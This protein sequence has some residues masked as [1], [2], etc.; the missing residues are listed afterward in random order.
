MSPSLASRCRRATHRHLRSQIDSVWIP[1]A[2]LATIFER[3]CVTSR[4]ATRHGSSVPGPMESRRRVGKR[5]M[6][7]LSLGQSQSASPLWVL[8]NLPD[9]TQW[10]WKPPS[11]A[12]ARHRAENTPG[13]GLMQAIGNWLSGPAPEPPDTVDGGLAPGI[14]L[15]WT[16][17]GISNFTLPQIVW[18]VQSSPS[19]VI[20]TGLNFFFRDIASGTA[21]TTAPSLA[22]FCNSWRD[23]LTAGIF[24]AEAV[25]SVLDGIQRGLD[26]AQSDTEQRLERASANKFKLDILDATIDGLSSRTT[27]ENDYSDCIAWSSVLQRI[28]ELQMNSIRIFTK[29]MEHVPER[30]LNDMPLAVLANL[31]AYLTASG[32]GRT[33]SSLTRQVSKIAV[34]LGRIDIASHPLVFESGTQFV[35]MHRGSE[36]P[37]EYPRVRWAWLQLLARLPG[38]DGEYLAKICSVLEAGRKTQPLSNREICEIYM[39]KH[40]SSIK[41]ITVLLNTLQRAQEKDAK[42]Y[43][44][45]SQALWET[46]QF[47][48][49]KGLCEFLIKIGREQD[50]IRLAKQ[51]RNLMKNEATLLASI[52]IRLHNPILAM[53]IFSLYRKNNTD[54]TRFWEAIASNKI[55]E[56]LLK[57][58]H[59]RHNKILSAMRI[60]RSSQKRRYKMLGTRR[61]PQKAVKAAIAFALSP[62]LSS[63]TS[64][65]LISQCISYLERGR[66]AV[67]PTAALRALLHNITRDLAEGRPGRTTRL[68]W[69]LSLLY[70]QA[71]RDRMVQMG[72][73]LKQWRGVNMRRCRECVK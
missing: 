1:E 9:L 34:P 64:F 2:L 6:G 47:D 60:G 53:E 61:D 46:D 48:L 10:R 71:G 21:R 52:A 26:M 42:C 23:C 29:A 37:G 36:D 70:K 7:E 15:E 59:L 56:T 55:L 68:R 54:A 31:R 63:R 32:S 69:F 41:D 66:D 8:E 38:V 24:S 49:V 11:L 45:L 18:D 50:V 65:K 17:E 44:F 33:R 39:I 19:E 62:S 22:Y 4:T 58:Q 16:G 73:A 28:S 51:F 57:S 67:I 30:Y 40:R 13:R 12:D 14:I 5:R 20:Q 27:D 72:L 43:G 35:L 3:Y 25:D